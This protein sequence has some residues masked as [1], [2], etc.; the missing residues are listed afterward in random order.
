MAG[1]NRGYLAWLEPLRGWIDDAANIG[2]TAVSTDL[3]LKKSLALKISGS[4]T[5]LKNRRIEFTPTPPYASLR[6][7]RLNFSETK[8]VSTLVPEE[9][10]EPS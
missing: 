10:V 1:L 3:A 9:G 4:N 5:F 7:A 8:L 6:E 2:E